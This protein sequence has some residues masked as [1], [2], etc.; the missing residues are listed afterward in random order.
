MEYSVTTAFSKLSEKFNFF[1]H[2]NQTRFI[3]QFLS[4]LLQFALLASAHNKHSNP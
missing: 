1:L 2:L 4:V 3:V